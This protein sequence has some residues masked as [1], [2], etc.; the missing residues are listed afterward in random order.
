MDDGGG[1]GPETL[2]L[3]WVRTDGTLFINGSRPVDYH[4]FTSGPLFISGSHHSPASLERLTRVPHLPLRLSPCFRR[5][6]VPTGTEEF[7]LRRDPGSLRQGVRGVKVE[8]VL[9]SSPVLHFERLT[10]HGR[11]S[12]TM[13]ARPVPDPRPTVLTSSLNGD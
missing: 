3:V 6:R 9:L 11:L 10:D 13:V 2:R 5:Y 7:S 1:R 12:E 8:T 4:G